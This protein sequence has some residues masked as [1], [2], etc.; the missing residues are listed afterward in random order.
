MEERALKAKL[1]KE[2]AELKLKKE[3]EIKEVVRK[4]EEERIKAIRDKGLDKWDLRYD[5]CG[6]LLTCYC[7]WRPV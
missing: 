2:Q 1:E 7:S 6:L 3:R 5:R 4:K